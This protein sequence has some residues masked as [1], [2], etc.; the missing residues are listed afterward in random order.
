MMRDSKRFHYA[1]VVL[2]GTALAILA[3][4]GLR[5]AFGVFIQPMEAEFGW[6]RTALSLVASLSFLLNGASGPIVGRLADR[7]GARGGLA[8]S[9]ILVGVGALGAALIVSLWQLYA[10]V[11][12]IIA[13]GAGGAA[14][15]VAAALA[16]RWFD[17]RRGLAIGIV[18]GAMAGGQLLVVPLAMWL[19]VWWGWRTAFAALGIS[20][21]VIVLPLILVFV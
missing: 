13:V 2:G 19:T 3:A 4:S 16:A 8:R 9:G 14:P 1:W 21:L 15:G 18:G 17:Q 12:V 6:D 10:T 20:F 5:S 11:G 7:W